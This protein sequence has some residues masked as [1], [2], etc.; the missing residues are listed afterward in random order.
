MPQNSYVC[1]VTAEQAEAFRER[2]LDRG[3][4]VDQVPYSRFRARHNKT[5]VTAYESG[6][7][8]IQGRGTAELVEFTLEPEILGQ[9]RFGYED[10]LRAVE[11]PE[12]FE[13]HAG[14]DESG[15][16]DYFGPL[17]I[18][19]YYVDHDCAQALLQLGVQDSKRIRS[20]AR[21]AKIAGGIRELGR[22]RFA[23]VRIGPEA[24]NRLYGSFGNVNRLLAWGHAKALEELLEQQPDCPRA[25]ADQFGPKERILSALKQ[26]GRR[27]KLEQRPKAEEDV[28]VAAASILARHEFV[29]QLA[30]LGERCGIELPKGA[31]AKVR[32]AAGALVAKD[33][34]EALGGV[35]KLHFRTTDVV[36][37]RIPQDG[38][39]PS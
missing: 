34:A 13:A 35:A 6:K 15:K 8:T 33:G 24:Y 14:I 39:A 16:G 18:A 3:W 32:E 29:Q 1:E 12:M 20:D 10:E 2:L 25:L 30:R 22:D 4:E 27:I 26:K 9:A 31:S 7:L 38:S 17:V 11:H 37:G 36:L 23:I 21:I 19:A 28:A 5:T